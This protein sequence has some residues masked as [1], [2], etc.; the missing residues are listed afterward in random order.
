MEQEPL[1]L[2]RELARLRTKFHVRLA[3]RRN[4]VVEAAE[5]ERFLQYMND[6]DLQ[7]HLGKTLDL[8]WIFKIW[9]K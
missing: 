2:R 9:R 6:M 3:K 4:I 8:S 1:S 5:V 7:K